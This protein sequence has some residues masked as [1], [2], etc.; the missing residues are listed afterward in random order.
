MASV[1]VR[2]KVAHLQGLFDI[3]SDE[4]DRLGTDIILPMQNGYQVFRDYWLCQHEGSWHLSKRGSAVAEFTT[5]RAALAWCIADKHQ[6]WQLCQRIQQLDERI[7]ITDRGLEP[8][9]RRWRAGTGNTALV[10]KIQHRQ[11]QRYTAKAELDKCVSRAKYL[12]IRGLRN[13]TQRNKQS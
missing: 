13:D 5:S 1:P 9:L 12:Q 10:A 11:Q 3:A 2:P 6:E 7:A 8:R 4:L